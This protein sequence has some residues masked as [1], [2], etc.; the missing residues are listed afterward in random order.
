[1]DEKKK[2]LWVDD[3]ID[4]LRPHVLF[5]ENKGYS[6]KTLTNAEDAIELVRNEDFDIM[7]LDE[8]LHGMDGLTALAELKEINPGL[9]IIMVTKSEE[10]SLMEEAIGSK[11]DDYLTKPVNP[12]QILLVC[13]KILDKGKIA[14]QIISRDYT[15]EFNQISNRI[16]GPMDWRDWIDVHVKLSEWDVELDAHPDLGL[17]QILYE[18]KRDC[19]IEYGRFIEKSYHDWLNRPDGPPLSVDVVPRYVLPHVHAGKNTVLLILDALRLDQWMVLEPLMRTYFKI[20]R[21]YYY[22]ILPTATPY[23]RNAI[24]AG[25]F[26]SEIEARIPELWQG[27]KEEDDI[28]LNRYE[29]ELLEEQLKRLGVEL[30]PGPK[31]AKILDVQESVELARKINEYGSVPLSALVLNFVD[32]LAHS[33]SSSNIIKEMIPNEAAF[34]STTRS[35]FEHSHLY[36]AMRKLA[37]NGNTIVVTSDHGS[38]RGLHGTKV[39]GDRETSTSLRYKYGRNIKVDPKDAMIIDN[40][41]EYKL[42]A[43]GINS[44]YI[45][46]KEDFYFVYPT[47]YH[48]F[49]NYYA[50]SFQHGGIS[51]EEMVLPIITL[52]PR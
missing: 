7:L 31:Y 16:M 42:P 14:S 24:F 25:L 12:S 13:K 50:D 23:A 18:Q 6:V 20:T 21:D 46:A 19:N 5:L 30:K 35:W 28:S 2:I 26:P 17:K 9:P 39:V 1:M 44:N 37:A 32:I 41:H 36:T 3:E 47:N 45:F 8:M 15:S 43:R 27:N 51:L 49:L 33:R 29:L 10:E 40:P 4:L 22:S 38:I 52:E 11:I 48:Y 34:R